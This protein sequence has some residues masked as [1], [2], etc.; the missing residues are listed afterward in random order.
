MRYMIIERF[1]NGDPVPVYTRF[2]DQGRLAPDG[3]TYVE[4]WVTADLTL[5]FQVM[6]CDDPTLVHQW[7]ERWSDLVE[8]EV[9]PVITSGEAAERVLAPE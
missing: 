4:S 1:R 3:L 6:E 7:V 5:C 2:R 8:F 9:L